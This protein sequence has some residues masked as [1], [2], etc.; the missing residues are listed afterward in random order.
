MASHPF[1]RSQPD[2]TRDPAVW[3]GHSTTHSTPSSP[4]ACA[5]VP[6]LQAACPCPRYMSDL[7]GVR[8]RGLAKERHACHRAPCSCRGWKLTVHNGQERHQPL[9]TYRSNATAHPGPPAQSALA[10]PALP[11]R[12]QE[13]RKVGKPGAAP[14]H[15]GAACAAARPYSPCH[16]PDAHPACSVVRAQPRAADAFMRVQ[17]TGPCAAAA[18]CM[19]ADGRRAATSSAGNAMLCALHTAEHPPPPVPPLV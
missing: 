11:S 2:L 18:L 12:K 6:Q 16:K 10:R 17:H 14:A 1:C 5:P 19:D 15:V 4:T 13:P 3:L 9:C 7:V 8:T